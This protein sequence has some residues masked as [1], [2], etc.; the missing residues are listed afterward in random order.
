MKLTD[1]QND[2]MKTDDN[3]FV[4]NFRKWL[5]LDPCLRR[6]AGPE[7]LEQ[8]EA[9][10]PLL[11]FFKIH[12]LNPPDFAQIPIEFD[13]DDDVESILRKLIEPMLGLD[14]P[15]ADPAIKGSHVFVNAV[16][17]IFCQLGPERRAVVYHLFQGHDAIL[18]PLLLAKGSCTAE[19]YAGGLMAAHL[20]LADEIGAKAYNAQL[21]AFVKDAKTAL[22]LMT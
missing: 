19:E 5:L 16:H 13:E 18:Y 4:L 1:M 14:N 10:K 17:D 12:R 6:A 8:M 11:R 21:R 3:R 9:W 15:Q 20:L 2:P 22:R 7:V